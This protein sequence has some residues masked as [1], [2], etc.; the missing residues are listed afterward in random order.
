MRDY[1]LYLSDIQEATSKIITFT[2]GYSYKK[3]SMDERTIDAVIRNLEV[4]GEA[5]K[6][7]PKKL[8]EQYQ[9]VDWQAMM[10]LRNII[11]HE[12]FGVDL[13]IIWK[14]VRERIPELNKQIKSIIADL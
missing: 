14:T 3:F 12:Y 2:K 9:E 5:S 13:K 11:A 4:I 8:R 10:G 6:H 1:K 7:V